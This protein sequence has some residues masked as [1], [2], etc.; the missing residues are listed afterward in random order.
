MVQ[1]KGDV[2]TAQ[3]TVT[4]QTKYSRA[5]TTASAAAGANA[6]ASLLPPPLPQIPRTYFQLSPTPDALEHTARSFRDIRH[7]YVGGAVLSV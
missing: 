1:L 4:T 6:A 7:D 2:S 3:S 5:R